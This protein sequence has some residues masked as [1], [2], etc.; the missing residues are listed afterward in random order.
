MDELFKI[1]DNGQWELLS[2][3]IVRDENGDENLNTIA[4]FHDGTKKEF[5]TLTEAHTHLLNSDHMQT[6]DS[7]R[8]FH[9]TRD[10]AKKVKLTTSMDRRKPRVDNRRADSGKGPGRRE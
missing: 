5:G 2:K 4:T 1:H 8:H 6:D 7:G 10:P 9:Q 3:N